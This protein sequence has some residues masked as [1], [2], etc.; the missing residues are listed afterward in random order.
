MSQINILWKAFLIVTRTI[1]YYE[2]LK[3]LKIFA[4]YF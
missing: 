2:F 1:E 4:R 3:N